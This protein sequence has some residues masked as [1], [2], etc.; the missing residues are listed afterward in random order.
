MTQ[1]SHKR[2]RLASLSAA[3]QA[4]TSAQPAPEALTVTDLQVFPLKE[5]VSGRRYFVLKVLTGSGLTGFGEGNGLTPEDW[6]KARRVVLGQ[7]ASSYEVMRNRLSPFPAIEAAVNTA[8]L[9]VMGKFTQAP[10]YQVLGGPTRNA[11]RALTSLSGESDEALRESLSRT[12]DS[13]FRAFAVPL[14]PVKAFNHGQDFV[15]AVG[16][17]LERL[18]AAGGDDLDFVLDGAGRLSPGDASSLAGA[19][20]GLHLLWFDECCRLSNLATL[21]KIAAETVTPLGFGREI[22]DSG[23]FQNLLREQVVDV[24]RPS[25]SRNGLSQIRRMAAL[26]EAYYVAV[27]PYHDGGPVGTAAALHLAASLPNFFI[28]QIPVPEAEPDR[29]MRREITQRPVE[30][31]REGFAALPAGAGLGIAV[32]EEALE[33]YR[34]RGA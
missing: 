23:D 28:Q 11:A 32:N 1:Q 15:K 8:L 5:P 13:G 31:V 24:L 20:E 9:D 2:V 3:Q 17:R 10:I 14:P 6:E 19:F 22:Q 7:P 29:T 30:T 16:K 12:R 4:S 26:A 25:L 21:R 34:E 33:K 27:A 18:R